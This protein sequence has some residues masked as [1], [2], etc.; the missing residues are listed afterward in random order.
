ME[1]LHFVCLF[2]GGLSPTSANGDLFLIF[3]INYSVSILNLQLCQQNKTPQVALDCG[4]P[5]CAGRP[6]R[7]LG[8]DPPAPAR[9][10]SRCTCRVRGLCVLG[11][12]VCLCLVW[13]DAPPNL[14]GPLRGCG[15]SS[16][17]PRPGQRRAV[18]PGTGSH[19]HLLSSCSVVANNLWPL[20]NPLG[21]HG[22]IP[23]GRVH[24]G[25]ISLTMP[26]LLRLACSPYGTPMACTHV[27]LATC[28]V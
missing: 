21:P 8:R 12:L 28:A 6:V 4:A 17:G 22:P 1:S 18:C 2:L 3:N 5:Q 27:P 20:S 24:T 25:W 16:L 9:T 26:H 13:T 7:D 23:A 19:L 15:H 11:R 14:T 10:D